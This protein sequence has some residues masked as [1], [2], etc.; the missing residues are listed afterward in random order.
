MPRELL[1]CRLGNSA[2]RRFPAST[3]NYAAASS[4]LPSDWGLAATDQD[5][6]GLG[7]AADIE[8]LSPG[9]FL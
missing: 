6:M 2:S 3:H 8:R 7:G 4:I 1:S 9:G 5:G